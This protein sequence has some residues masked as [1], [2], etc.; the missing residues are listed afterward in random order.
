MKKLFIGISLSI[1]FVFFAVAMSIFSQQ[2][3]SQ[4]DRDGALGCLIIATPPTLLGGWLVWDLQ[5][6]KRQS[7]ADR[8]LA[9]E[10]VLLQH[11][12]EQR[13]NITVIS[14]AMASKLPLSDAKTYLEQKS[15]QLNGT[16]SIDEN[17]GTTYHFHL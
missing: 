9:I 6:Q 3:P 14:F 8:L 13:G 7:Q 11:I 12:Q 15:L 16:F 1:G 10:A 4:E 2:N 17:G 5:R